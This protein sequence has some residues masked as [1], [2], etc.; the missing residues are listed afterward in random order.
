[1]EAFTISPKGSAF[2]M[3]RPR[4]IN[5]GIMA[6]ALSFGPDGAL[7]MADWVGGYPLDEKGAIWRVDEETKNP[8]R[9]ETQKL[10]SA[11]F[12]KT[13]PDA[14]QILLAHADQRVRLAAQLELASRKA[15]PVFIEVLDDGKAPLLAKLHAIWGLGIGL[16][17]DQTDDSQ[18]HRT[19]RTPILKSKPSS[20]K[21]SAM[22]LPRSARPVAKPSPTS[23][24][25]RTYASDFTPLSTAGKIKLAGC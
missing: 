8:A 24:P 14:L 25:R 5:A 17:Q 18:L 10:L 13:E 16:R 20:S 9:A 23:S 21:C 3:S 4:L 15:W 11:G 6:S 22:L 7:Y 2:E 12:K 1:M 19:S